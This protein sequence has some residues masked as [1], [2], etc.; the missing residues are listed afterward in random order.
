MGFYLVAAVN[1]TPL[2]HQEEF[3]QLFVC[4]FQRLA[5]AI[6]WQ[7]SLYCS[8]PQSHESP[9]QNPLLRGRLRGPG[10]DPFYRII[11]TGLIYLGSLNPIPSSLGCGMILAIVMGF[12][13]TSGLCH[14]TS[15]FAT[16]LYLKTISKWW[17]IS[18]RDICNGWRGT[19]LL[20]NGLYCIMCQKL[21]R[22]VSISASRGAEVS[23]TASWLELWWHNWPAW[24]RALQWIENISEPDEMHLYN[25]TNMSKPTC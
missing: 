24:L 22:L 12:V 3:W 8:I 1:Q 19:T 20:A 14:C 2:A 9:V 4:L 11:E 6:V 18:L 23:Y 5:F 25:S 7:T 21:W 10:F 15:L 13:D 16:T 17:W